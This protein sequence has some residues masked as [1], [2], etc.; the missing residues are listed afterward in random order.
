M[1]KLG[2]NS[3]FKEEYNLK[4]ATKRFEK[5]SERQGKAKLDK[6]QVLK[7]ILATFT[8]KAFFNKLKESN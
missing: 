3:G 6:E 2:L 8:N 7:Q 5:K 1:M 4:L